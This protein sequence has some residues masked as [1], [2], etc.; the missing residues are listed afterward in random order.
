MSHQSRLWRDIRMAVKSEKRRSHR[1]AAVVA[2]VAERYK[3]ATPL[4]SLMT[5]VFTDHWS[6]LLGEIAVFSFIILLVTGVFLTIFFDSSMQTFTYDGSYL[7]L[8][9]TEVS[10]AYDSVLD[11]SFEV[12]GGMFVRQ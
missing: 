8:R 11:L 9:G 6:F 10:K 7:A 1:V 4:R 5:R 3:V 12:R 2:G